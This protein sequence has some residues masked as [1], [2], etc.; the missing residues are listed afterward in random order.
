MDVTKISTVEVNKK[1]I[2]INDLVGC[3]DEVQNSVWLG[4]VIKIGLNKIEVVAGEM[5]YVVNK[6]DIL[7]H[8]PKIK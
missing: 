3:Y 2:K 6:N 4:K 1:D 5:I 7:I 8:Y